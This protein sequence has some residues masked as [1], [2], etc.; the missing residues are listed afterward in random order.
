MFIALCVCAYLLGSISFAIVLSRR[1]GTTDPRLQGSGNPG[2]SNMLRLFGKRLALLTL[3]GDLAKGLLPVLCAIW[4]NFSMQDQAWVGFFAILGHLY[5]LYHRF[6]GGKGVA[7]T[8]GVLLG[9][10]PPAALLALSVWLLAFYL[11]RTSSLASLSALPVSLPLLAWQQPEAILPA[12]LLTLLLFWR[13]RQN[14]KQLLLGTE[15]KF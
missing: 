3:L 8:A 1:H 14:L 11:S 10:Y 4:L 9:L 12:S 2:A 6:Q 5:P 15:Y 7:T 13:H